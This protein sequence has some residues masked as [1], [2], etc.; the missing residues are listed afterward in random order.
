ML[1]EGGGEAPVQELAEVR[2]VNPLELPI[3]HYLPH[4]YV[5]DESVRLQVYQ[6]LAAAGTE[7]ALD[8]QARRLKDRF[9]PL[10]GP[11]ENLVYSLRVKLAAQAAGV[12]AIQGDGQEL[13]IR[14][15]DNQGV[16]I[17][18]VASRHRDVEATRTRLRFQLA[19][20]GDGWR[21]RLLALL[22]ELRQEVA[23][24]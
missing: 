12:S 21:E 4:D 14:L 3:D 9:G 24:A 1:H 5:P 7:A 19:R 16:D 2:S 10:P 8:T 18:R 22:D 23:A 13:E 20:S 6:Q 11:V 15:H 17:A